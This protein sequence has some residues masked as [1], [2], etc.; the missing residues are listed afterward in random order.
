MQRIRLR[1]ERRAVGERRRPALPK[2]TYDRQLTKKPLGGHCPVDVYV[3]VPLLLVGPIGRRYDQ[4]GLVRIINFDAATAPRLHDP[5]GP[6]ID[7]LGT[8]CGQNTI[9]AQLQTTGVRNAADVRLIADPVLAYTG[10]DGA[11]DSDASPE[12]SI[13]IRAREVRRRDGCLAGLD[14]QSVTAQGGELARAL[15]VV[16]DAVDRGEVRIAP[17]APVGV[18]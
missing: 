4:G 9:H 7:P 16:V 17:T 11:V 14:F 2:F 12:P 13:G 6:K 15:E 8:Q 3:E 10:G 5:A 18:T 1:S